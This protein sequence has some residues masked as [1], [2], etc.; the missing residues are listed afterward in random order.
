MVNL[1]KQWKQTTGQVIVTTNENSCSIDVDLFLVGGYLGELTKRV[2]Q[3]RLIM[4]W[5]NV[6]KVN[7]GVKVNLWLVNPRV[8]LSMEQSALKMP[9]SNNSLHNGTAWWMCNKHQWLTDWLV[10]T[11][12][13]FQGHKQL[14]WKWARDTGWTIF[15]N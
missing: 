9:V 10:H 15:N 5:K 3:P 12:N 11:D 6:H 1:Y 4:S 14:M 2:T 13:V 8:N 7:L